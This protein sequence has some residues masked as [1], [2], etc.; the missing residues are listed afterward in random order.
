MSTRL[1]DDRKARATALR[2]MRVVLAALRELAAAPPPA[3][4]DPGP[5]QPTPAPEA[6]LLEAI[7]AAQ[8]TGQ[9]MA[10]PQG[11]SVEY[12]GPTPALM[13]LV[14]RLVDLLGLSDLEREFWAAGAGRGV[15]DAWDGLAAYADWLEDRGNDAGAARVRKLTPQPGD[16]LVFTLPRDAGAGARAWAD[17][18]AEAVADSLRLLEARG[19][20]VTAMVLPHDARLD[21]LSARQMAELGLVP[22]KR[23][24]QV[25]E[26]CAALAEQHHYYRLAADLRADLSLAE[27]EAAGAPAP[28]G[29]EPG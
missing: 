29:G 28:G 24:A 4:F 2:E 14:H 21:R 15:P 23:L 3:V 26:R 11:G 25:R 22:A 13:Q 10:L 7:R 17:A 8:A 6:D 18:S 16:V 9:P 19:V 27:M 12:T 5:G 1:M 20:P